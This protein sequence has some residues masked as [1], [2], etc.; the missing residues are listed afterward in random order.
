MA[1][2]NN[3]LFYSIFFIVGFLSFKID[4]FSHF[5]FM[6]IRTQDLTFIR[7]FC[8]CSENPVFRVQ[9]TLNDVIKHPIT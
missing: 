2:C 5:W 6:N 7:M 8:Y 3:Y 4:A 1:L 9:G